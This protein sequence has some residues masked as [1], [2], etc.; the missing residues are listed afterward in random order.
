MNKKQNP[1]AEANREPG[2]EKNQEHYHNNALRYENQAKFDKSSL[3]FPAIVE[4]AGVTLH[5]AGTRFSGCCPFHAEKTPSFI[6]YPDGRF[7]CFGCGAHGD[8]IDFV[9]R[10]HGLSFPDALRY[11]GLKSGNVDMKQIRKQRGERIMKQNAV[12]VYHRA[13][14]SMADELQALIAGV[15]K[16]MQSATW[17][18]LQELSG[19]VHSL[20]WWENS[21]EILTHGDESEKLSLYKWRRTHEF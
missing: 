17:D 20:P 11:L 6:V 3:D 9:Q 19:L 2:I 13:L 4:A 5:K 7:H 15:K 10:L 16:F 1:A 8:S 21:L 18:Q 14:N 12:K